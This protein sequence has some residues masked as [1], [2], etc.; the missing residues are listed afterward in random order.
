ETWSM[1]PALIYLGRVALQSGG[2][3]AEAARL[4]GEG[5]KLAKER[6]DKRVAAECL[7]GIAAVVGVHGD[8]AEAA[9]LFGAGEALLEA[10]GATPSSSEIAVSAQFVPPVKDSL[11][12]G[13][14]TAE[15]AAGRARAPDE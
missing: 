7:Q 11:G 4:F 13:R 1:S 6:G 14:A 5:L 12:E 2:E 9:R 3:P 8:H 10:I 15:W